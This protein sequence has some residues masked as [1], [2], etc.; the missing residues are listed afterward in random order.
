VNN[1]AIAQGSSERSISTV[2]ESNKA[3]E[4][5]KVVHQNFFSNLHSIDAF[6]VGCGT[7]GNELLAQIARQ[8]SALL[9]RGISLKVYG[10][11]N[12]RKLLLKKGGIEIQNG[13]E[14]ALDNSDVSFS[15]E[16]IADFVV[17]NSL[18]NPVIIDC[19]SSDQVAALYEQMMLAGFHVV[20]PNKKA[21]TREIAY[22]H[23][24]RETAQQTNRQFLYE[25]TVGAGLPVIDNLQ[26]LIYAGDEL[27]RFEGILSGSLS[28]VFGKL[29]EGLSLSE[30]T[31][32]AK[33]NGFTEPDPRDDLSGTD[34]ARKL[35]IM[36]RESDLNL[37]LC[38]I[39]VESVLPDSFDDSGD[40][41]T[42]MKNLPSLDGYFQD[43]VETAKKQNKV[44]RYVGSIAKGKCRVSI[45]AVD[46]AHPL[47]AVKEGENALAIH[48]HYYQPIPYVIRGYG[49]GAAVTAAGVFADVMRTMPW[50]Q[51]V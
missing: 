42:F 29:D 8:Q 6:L 38:D 22:Y 32:I 15:V 18:V 45:Q 1:V 5:V 11:A 43:R 21:N 39:E 48:S 14:E 2:I 23:K 37:E 36:A 35:L 30:A 49:A 24:L 19:T 12:S 44:L 26:K 50:K 40:I 33:K 20:T 28:F 9:E 16:N 34:V 3:K 51:D 17:N 25:T 41:D 10:I 7:V 46:A 4:A 27:V 13:W 31:E 47:Y